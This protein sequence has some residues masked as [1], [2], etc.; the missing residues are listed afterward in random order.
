M[1][2]FPSKRSK[3]PPRFHSNSLDRKCLRK[4]EEKKKKE[5]N[6]RDNEYTPRSGL[7]SVE[8]AGILYYEIKMIENT[9]P[10]NGTARREHM[11]RIEAREWKGGSANGA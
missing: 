3:S 5:K 8:L 6:Q 10:G 2:L 9:I 7:L 1:L 4:K 11:K